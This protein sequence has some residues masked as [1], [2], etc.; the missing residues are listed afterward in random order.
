M[1]RRHMAYWRDDAYQ[2][3]GHG[4]ELF[5]TTEAS[6]PPR[7]ISSMRRFQ[8]DLEEGDKGKKE[9]EIEAS[10]IQE[11]ELSPPLTCMLEVTA[12]APRASGGRPDRRSLRLDLF[13]GRPD[14][15]SARGSSGAGTL[16]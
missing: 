8:R 5:T 4:V 1:D 2:A 12:R 15:E 9:R 16:L 7:Q 14:P 13:G 10:Q 11:L 6:S 3:D